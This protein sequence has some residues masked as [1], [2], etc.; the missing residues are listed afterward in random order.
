MATKLRTRAPAARS[1][2]L[3]G[4]L[5]ALRE[6]GLF[7]SVVAV[8]HIVLSRIF[9]PLLEPTAVEYGCS[10]FAQNCPLAPAEFAGTGLP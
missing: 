6:T 10:R 7:E 5:A 9:C 3:P 1:V 2:Q 4:A 8:G